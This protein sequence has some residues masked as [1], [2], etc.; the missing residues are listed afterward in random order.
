M[1]FRSNKL[2]VP[3]L[4]LLIILSIGVFIQ[5]SL[6]LSIFRDDVKGYFLNSFI[7]TPFN[8]QSQAEIRLNNSKLEINLNLTDQDKPIMKQFLSNLN[9]D[10]DLSFLSLELDKNA[11]ASL[12]PLLPLAI[13]PIPSYSLVNWI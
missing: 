9:Q 11:A 10:Q 7:Q 1:K 8:K 4:I 13:S 2:L 6:G 5:Y 12:A 3:L